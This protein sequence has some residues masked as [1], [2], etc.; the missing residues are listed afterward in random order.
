VANRNRNANGSDSTHWRIGFAGNTSSARSAAL[1]V[2]RRAPQEGQKWT[3]SGLTRSDEF[4]VP[5]GDLIEERLFGSVAS[6]ARRIHERW[7]TRACPPLAMT[8]RPCDEW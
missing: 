8:S 3:A 5:L 1:S 7:R 6:I 4:Q 2:I